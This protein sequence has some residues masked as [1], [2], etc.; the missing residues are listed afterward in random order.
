MQYKKE[1]Q[2]MT[3]IWFLIFAFMGDK[4]RKKDKLLLM[5]HGLSR[6]HETQTLVL[7]IFLCT[8]AFHNMG[9]NLRIRIMLFTELPT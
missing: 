4:N 7:L 2:Q 5:L 6:S 1:I 8:G 3:I 9:L